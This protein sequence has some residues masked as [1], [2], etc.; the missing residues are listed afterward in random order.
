MLKYFL[1]DHPLATKFMLVIRHNVYLICIV[2]FLFINMQNTFLGLRVALRIIFLYQG[3]EYARKRVHPDLYTNENMLALSG[4]IV[5]TFF[6][7]MLGMFLVWF[8]DNMN[9]STSL[10][11]REARRIRKSVRAEIKHLENQKLMLDALGHERRAK[12]Q[13]LEMISD[14]K[15]MTL[16]MEEVILRY[17]HTSIALNPEIKKRAKLSKEDTTFRDLFDFDAAGRGDSSKAQKQNRRVIKF[18]PKF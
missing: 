6:V 15:A 5:S 10:Y 3:S 7:F 17:Q 11:S 2:T 1:T 12:Q 9:L 4:L 13:A 16:D 8:I 14:L 18:K